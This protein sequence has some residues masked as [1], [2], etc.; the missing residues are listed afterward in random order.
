MGRGRIA[1]GVAATLCALAA[2]WPASSTALVVEEVCFDRSAGF[3]AGDPQLLLRGSA[4][5]L[6]DGT[7]R[8]TR[9]TTSQ[10]GVAFADQEINLTTNLGFDTTFTFRMNQRGG[11]GDEDGPGADGIAFIFE[12]AVSPTPGGVGGGIGYDGLPNSL[13]VEYDT[14]R[15]PFDP[16]GNHISVHSRGTAPNSADESASLGRTLAIPQMA[17]GAL[18]TTRIRYLPPGVGD[19]P[20][21]DVFLDDLSTP[22]LHVDVDLA[23]LLDL[24]AG[25][26]YVGLSA[27]TGAG[28][29]N[30]D[31]TTWKACTS[32]GVEEI[33]VEPQPDAYGTDEDTPLQVAAP[34]VLDNDTASGG[35]ISLT[36]ASGP[37]HGTL[38]LAADGGFTY[39]PDPDHAGSDGFAYELCVKTTCK[40]TPVAITV[41]E[42]SEPTALKASPAVASVLPG[43]TTYLE[44]SA[45]LTAA[46]RPV[47][48]QWIAFR[49]GGRE[50]CRGV[51]GSDGVARCGGTVPT[52][53]QT[54][55]ARGYTARFAGAPDLRPSS[56]NGPVLAVQGAPLP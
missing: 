5:V 49:A 18:H 17:N 55:L 27:A 30:H 41:R 21:L 56:A 44:L 3:T 38:A 14:Y 34:G 10:S 53:L 47:A 39:T 22:V 51:T 52:L 46:G 24:E 15:N 45:R 4:A 40:T 6:T 8:L 7:L 36:T 23:Q 43:A 35:T 9:A 16:N 48:G 19:A 26:G 11:I 33:V 28:Y 50:A 20:G 1:V 29:E 37:A 32:D 42:I 25:N 2:G 13:A 31:I 12:N 54:L